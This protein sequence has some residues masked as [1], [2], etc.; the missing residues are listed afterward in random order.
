MI[1]DKL[2][3]EI[4]Q[5]VIACYPEEC[6][7]LVMQKSRVQKFVP[8][9]NAHSDPMSHFVPDAQEYFDATNESGWEVVTLV[10]SHC[11]DGANTFP[12]D[13]DVANCNEHQIPYTIV[14]WPEGD[15]RIIQPEQMPLIGRPWVLGVYDCWGLIMEFHKL[16]GVHLNDYRV[17]NRWWID[18]SK[19]FYQDNWRD[20]GFVQKSD[21]KF[22]DM[23]I[24]QISSPVWNHAGIYVG[25]NTIIHHTEGK[26]SKR[27]Y[28]TGWYDEHKVLICRHKDLDY[29]ISENY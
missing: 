11:G 17:D 29:D 5:H 4:F 24:F 3:P 26:L 20:A 2:K 14:S 9:K 12:S 19:N 7:G 15:M 25:D 28:L 21:L 8:L 1:Q 18:G 27:D 22:G 16:H 6:C 10:H 23:I 13:S